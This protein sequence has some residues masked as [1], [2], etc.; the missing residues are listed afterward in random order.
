M[1]E[2]DELQ[3]GEIIDLGSVSVTEDEI[4][5]FAEEFDPQ[6][7]HVDA[8][9][10]AASM[11]G[12]LIASGWHTA[13]LFMRLLVDGFLRDVRS[14]GSPGIEQLRWPRPVRPGDVL[15]ARLEILETRVSSSRPGVGIVRSRSTVTD[16]DGEVVLELTATNFLAR[17]DA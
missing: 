2:F 9:A 4:V 15:H 16:G 13:S 7:F 12:G 5:A 3:V 6:P 14:L 11:F 1:R 17:D 8:D 10:A